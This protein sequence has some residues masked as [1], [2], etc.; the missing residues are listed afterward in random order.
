[1][2]RRNR[3]HHRDAIP[4]FEKSPS[5]PSGHT[6][7][8]TTILGTLA[9]LIALRQQKNLPQALTIGAAGGTA[10]TVGL[11]RVLLGAHWFTDVAVGW[12]TGAGWLA[13]IITSHRLYLTS[14]SDSKPTTGAE[15]R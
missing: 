1:M 7:N 2:I 10:V 13:L 6:L 9:Y 8:A 3:P 14:T 5:F 12:T 11:S 4:P 15:S